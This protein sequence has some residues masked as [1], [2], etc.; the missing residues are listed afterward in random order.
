MSKSCRL[1]G[2]L[3]LMFT[4][5]G[6][7][8]MRR[9]ASVVF[10]VV[11]VSFTL[12][13]S[14]SFQP[15]HTLLQSKREPLLKLSGKQNKDTPLDL[16]T[17]DPV[18]QTLASDVLSSRRKE[19]KNTNEQLMILSYKDLDQY[20]QREGYVRRTSVAFP[21]GPAALSDSAAALGTRFVTTTVGMILL[22]SIASNL[23]LIGSVIGFAYGYRITSLMKEEGDD[24]GATI[25]NN[26]T[27][28]LASLCRSCGQWVGRTWLRLQSAITS[29][30]FL[31]K[32]GELSME[33]YKRYAKLDQRFAIQ[34]KMD[35]WNALFVKGKQSFDAWERENQVG[36]RTLATLRTFWLVENKNRRNKYRV[37]Q[38]YQD[39]RRWIFK[40]YRKW[41]KDQPD[42]T[43]MGQTLI[44]INLWG[45]LFQWNPWVVQILAILYAGYYA[46]TENKD[47]SNSNNNIDKPLLLDLPTPSF[48]LQ[49]R[50]DKTR[51]AYYKT[52]SGNRRYFR[53]GNVWWMPENQRRTEPSWKF[54]RID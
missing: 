17:S 48:S 46:R 21:Q 4:T 23:W 25:I 45:L 51:Y 18:N 40:Q 38:V 53:K 5:L 27:D 11:A 31:Y 36:R 9:A 42:A 33:Y 24:D 12:T 3:F 2:K 28:P 26:T 14:F 50:I 54:W 39:S 52:T 35:A 10:F 49:P 43:R 37:V 34:S 19:K 30:W 22:S 6:T 16:T 41:Q 29:L 47:D 44:W 7:M 32:T 8:R 13:D 20:L 15:R 1:A